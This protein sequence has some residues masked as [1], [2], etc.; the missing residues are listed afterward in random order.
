MAIPKIGNIT[1]TEGGS[2]YVQACRDASAVA[3]LT[4]WDAFKSYDYESV[5]AAMS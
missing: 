1:L 4:E 3:I 5:V 2:D